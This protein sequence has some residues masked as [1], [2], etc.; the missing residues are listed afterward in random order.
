MMGVFYILIYLVR[1]MNEDLVSGKGGN[2][3][4]GVETW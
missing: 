1:V 2:G 3:A 4:H